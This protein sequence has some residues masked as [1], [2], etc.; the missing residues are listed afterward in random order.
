MSKDYYSIL[1]VDRNATEDQIKKAYR[2]KAMELHPDKNP[3]N[4]EAEARFKEAAEAY[5]VLSDSGKKANYDRF[6]SADGP[7]RGNPFAGG[8]HGF[9]MDDIFSQFGDIFGNPFGGQQRRQTRG[10]DLRMKVIVNIDDVI[11]GSVKKLR[12]KR[13][14]TCESCSGLGGSNPRTCL[15]CNGQGQRVVLQ[16]TPFGQIRTQSTCPDCQGSGQQVTNTCHDC[17][18]AGTI[19]K[20][21]VVDVDIPAGIATG[22]QMNMAGYG[23]CVRGGSPGDL[24][25]LIEEQQ[26]F[27]FRRDGDNI[28]IEKEIS[29]IDAICGSHTEVKTPRGNI[30]VFVQEGTDHG[31]MLRVGGKGIPH[32]QGHGVGDLLIRLSV[33]MPKNLTLDEKHEIEKLRNLSCFK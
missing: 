29:L 5:D 10:Q 4:A 30:R 22:M 21:Q 28:I 25:I 13:Q 15:T 32:L 3:G 1:G 6:G 33:K 16:N 7:S 24:H 27:S 31:H 18:G 20:E 12:Y 9:S 17:R 19:S 14:A 26:D 11:N 8:G 2:K 23:N